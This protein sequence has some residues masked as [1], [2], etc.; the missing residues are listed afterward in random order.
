MG[1]QVQ[2]QIALLIFALSPEEELQQ[3]SLS[4]E[5]GLYA[6]LNQH[7]LNLAKSLVTGTLSPRYNA[8][9]YNAGSLITQSSLS[10]Q[11]SLSML[12]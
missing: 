3:K 9:R 6:L 7:T 4:G 1:A 11:N 5:K 8:L 2:K 10:P 12:K